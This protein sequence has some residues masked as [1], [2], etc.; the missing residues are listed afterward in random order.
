[1]EVETGRAEKK[2][3]ARSVTESTTCKQRAS[4]QRP[5]TNT[6]AEGSPQAKEE[7]HA[8]QGG[9]RESEPLPGDGWM[10]RTD[11]EAVFC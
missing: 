9:G 3:K 10:M 2:R 7:E 5:P 1:M 6:V 4:G 11:Q 8:E